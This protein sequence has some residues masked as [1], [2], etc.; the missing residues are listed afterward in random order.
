MT[1]NARLK[2]NCPTSPF[3]TMKK[4]NKLWQNYCLGA[5]AASLMLCVPQMAHAKNYT[6]NGVAGD[7]QWTNAKNWAPRGVPGARDTAYIGGTAAVQVAGDV[8]L[9]NL[10]LGADASINND[11]ALNVDRLDEFR[12]RC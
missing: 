5:T 2:N 3:I 7:D 4:T 11:G 10:R 9:Q 8:T 12:R 1:D 6:W